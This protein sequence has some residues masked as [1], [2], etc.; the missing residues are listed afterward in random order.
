MRAGEG[1]GLKADDVFYFGNAVGESGNST[2]DAVVNG[3]DRLAAKQNRT[4]SALVSNR[5]DFNRDGR[6]DRDD[7]W[8]ARD[9]QASLRWSLKLITGPSLG[10]RLAP[11]RRTTV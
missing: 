2:S 11:V 8:L 6:V 3:V 9:N 4:A 1:T 10:P 7:E 5:F